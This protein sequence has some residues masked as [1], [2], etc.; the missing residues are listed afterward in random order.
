[1]DWPSPLT[2][3]GSAQLGDRLLIAPAS[4]VVPSPLRWWQ[5]WWREA[6]LILRSLW[7]GHI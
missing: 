6:R 2:L 7:R 3:D 5:V 4:P 1:M